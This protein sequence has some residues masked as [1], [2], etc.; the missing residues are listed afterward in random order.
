MENVSIKKTKDIDSSTVPTIIKGNTMKKASRLRGR[1]ETA[2][3][4]DVNFSEDGG[5]AG[6]ND[7]F[8]DNE[9]YESLKALGLFMNIPALRLGIVKPVLSTNNVD[10]NDDAMD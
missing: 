6:K 5:E 2:K 1:L 3:Q 7:L 9:E 10:E 8:L 4:V